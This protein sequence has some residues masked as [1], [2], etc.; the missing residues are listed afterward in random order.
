MKKV[1]VV[2]GLI[3]LVGLSGCG[4]S[5]KKTI[6]GRWKE[7]GGT[8][9][10]EFFKDGTVTVVDKGEPPLTGD[11]RFIDENRIR[12]DLKGLGELLGPVIAEISASKDEI[13]LTAPDGKIEKYRK[14][15]IISFSGRWEVEDDRI[16]FYEGDKKINTGQITEDSIILQGNWLFIKQKEAELIKTWETTVAVSKSSGVDSAALK[17][18]NT[19]VYAGFLLAQT[20]G[21]EEPSGVS[22]EPV[23]PT[24]RKRITLTINLWSDYEAR[25][26]ST[27]KLKKNGTFLMNI[28]QAVT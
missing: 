7:V 22:S 9:T 8:Q 14:Y 23:S 17:N 2:L 26:G 28:A 21:L 13:T 11:Y 12:M 4:K 18:K 10:I 27:L 19:Y 20:A 6:I 16:K 25:G 15:T 5:A 24:G 3:V 1:M